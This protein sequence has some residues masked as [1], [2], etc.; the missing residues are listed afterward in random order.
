MASS[1]LGRQRG[2]VASAAILRYPALSTGR[3]APYSNVLHQLRATRCYGVSMASSYL[4]RQRGH[5]KYPALARPR[6]RHR[7]GGSLF[8]LTGSALSNAL[9]RC[10]HGVVISWTSVRQY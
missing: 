6:S 1:Y 8:Q 5:T 9:L 7:P 3:V 10:E 4:G 2:N